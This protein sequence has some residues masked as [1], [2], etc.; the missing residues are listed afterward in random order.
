MNAVRKFSLVSALG[1]FQ[2]TAILKKFFFKN[3]AV[4]NEKVTILAQNQL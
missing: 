3:Y 1:K 4:S 2:S